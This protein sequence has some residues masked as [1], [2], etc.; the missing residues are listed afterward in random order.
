MVIDENRLSRKYCQI[1]GGLIKSFTP[2]EV[3]KVWVFRK[4]TIIV[5]G[6]KLNQANLKVFMC[7]SWLWMSISLSVW[8]CI[9]PYEATLRSGE[10]LIICGTE[11]TIYP[12]VII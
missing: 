5:K 1:K 3:C 10:R 11:F 8:G 12:S 4:T 7:V 6:K 2:V 9:P